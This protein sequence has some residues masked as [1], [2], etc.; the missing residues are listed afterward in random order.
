MPRRLRTKQRDSE[1]QRRRTANAVSNCTSDGIGD[2]AW[3]TRE[4]ALYDVDRNALTFY[5]DLTTAEKER[6]RA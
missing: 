5:C 4:F 2:T 3:G 1:G 6:Q